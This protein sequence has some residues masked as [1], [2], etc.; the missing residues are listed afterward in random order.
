MKRL[1]KFLFAISMGIALAG[2]TFGNGRICGPQ[3]PIAYCDHEAYEK[4]AHPTPYLQ[5]WK[6]MG[7]TSSGR[8]EDSISCGAN[9]DHLDN[10]AFSE[11]K[12]AKARL[13]NEAS[14]ATYH[15]LRFDWQRCMIKKGYRFVGDCRVEF[16]DS[17]VSCEKNS[18]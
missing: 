17:P 7:V 13:S 15:R 18:E 1:I 3:T 6:K 5:Y 14:I 4:L 12:I 10:V 2:C 16:P 9:D 11:E 8:R